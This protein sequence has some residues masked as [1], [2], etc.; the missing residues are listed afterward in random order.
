MTI[1]SITFIKIVQGYSQSG[2]DN[3]IKE[4]QIEK[5]NV[6]LTFDLQ[7]GSRINFSQKLPFRL[8]RLEQ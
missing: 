6:R 1:N 7:T 4:F 3:F 2:A 8:H 5:K